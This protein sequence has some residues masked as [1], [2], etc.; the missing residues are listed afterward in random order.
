MCVCFCVCVCLSVFICARV[1]ACLQSCADLCVGGHA[2]QEMNLTAQRSEVLWKH[3]DND[4][5]GNLNSSQVRG[6][7]SLDVLSEEKAM[8]KALLPKVT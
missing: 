1:S 2:C 3:Q 6:Q 8:S 4:E 7:L 5:I